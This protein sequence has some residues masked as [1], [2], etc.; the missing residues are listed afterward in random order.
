MEL[1]YKCGVALF[2]IKIFFVNIQYIKE[3]DTI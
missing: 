3:M 1:I 2:F